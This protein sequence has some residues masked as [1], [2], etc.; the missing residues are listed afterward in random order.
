[1]ANLVAGQQQSDLANPLLSSGSINS[2][3]NRNIGLSPKNRCHSDPLHYSNA[4]LQNLPHTHFATGLAPVLGDDVAH[5]MARRGTTSVVLGA[6]HTHSQIL[7]VFLLCSMSLGIGVFVLPGI[8][9]LI[10]IGPGL[11]ILAFYALLAL[12]TQLLVLECASISKAKSYEQLASFS[13]GQFGEGLLAFFMAI[14]LLTGNCGHIQTVGQLFH[15]II[16]WFYTNQDEEYG[17]DWKKTGIL[18]VVMLSLTLPWLFQ[19]SLHGLSGVGTISVMT[20]ILTGVSFIIICVGKLANGEGASGAQAPVYGFSKMS[21]EQFWKTDFWRACPTIAF[22]YTPLLELFPVYI[23]LNHRDIAR[24]KTSVYVS[25]FICFLIYAVV[26]TLVIVTYGTKTQPNSLYNV[27]VS[28]NWFNFCCFA[29]VIV[30]TLLYPVINYP[31]INALETILDLFGCCQSKGHDD[32]TEDMLQEAYMDVVNTDV[33]SSTM[34]ARKRYN[35]ND[36]TELSLL[37]ALIAPSVWWEYIVYHRR[38]VLSILFIF[39]VI[40]VDI[41]VT[42]LDDL[43]GLCGSLGLSFV[44]YIYPCIIWLMFKW[45]WKQL[46][47]TLR[48]PIGFLKFAF[49]IFILIFSSAVMVYSTAVIIMN[50]V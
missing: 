13:M 44:C 23:E 14:S 42:D 8:F 38:D 27:P 7:G 20:V 6:P 2:P 15:D 31:M 47:T 10:G 11:L 45:K 4:A 35:E 29:L 5:G 12:F 41:G 49:S 48:S 40:G 3:D 16:D 17:F 28:N 26:S 19:R 24:T 22:V 39:V 34:K 32:D 25:M 37:S 43:F 1:M 30:I 18:Y 21:T 9:L 36:I 46:S 50:I 33:S